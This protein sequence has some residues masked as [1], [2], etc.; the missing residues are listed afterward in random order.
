MRVVIIA[1]RGYSSKAP[2]NT[3]T[4]FDLALSSGFPHIEFDVHLSSD[5]IPIVIH[6]RT[7]DRT[8][9]GSGQ[10]N[11]MSAAD[12]QELNARSSF[13]H[14]FDKSYGES[15]VPTLEELLDRYKGKAH[16]YIELKSEERDLPHQVAHLLG[17]TGWIKHDQ[18]INHSVPGVTI[19]SFNM[20]HLEVSKLLMPNVSIG[21]LIMKLTDR[22]IQIAKRNHYH[23]ILPYVNALTQ[24]KIKLAYANGL[25]VATWGIQNVQDFRR[26]IENEVFAI[27]VD[28]PG[29]ALDLAKESIQEN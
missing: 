23:V 15:K 18:P 26:A 12:I 1:H 19:I 8:T 20:D 11:Q 17:Q 22:E 5:H 27:A 29:L 10:V 16:L 9:N 3:I 7:V 13:E 2:E 14:A 28:W 6:D 25:H 21:W 24:D 4:A